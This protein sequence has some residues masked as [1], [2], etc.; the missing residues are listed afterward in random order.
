MTKKEQAAH[1]SAG[2]SRPTE[3]QIAERAYNL[4]LARGGTDGHDVEDWLCA[5]AELR[6]TE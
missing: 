6:G 3:E 2:N 1:Q 5:E 4:F